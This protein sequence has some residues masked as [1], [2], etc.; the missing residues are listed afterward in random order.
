MMMQMCGTG[1]MIAGI[2]AT[3]LGVGLIASLIVLVWVVIARLRRDTQ[4][5]VSR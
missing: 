2:L 5:T 1:M 3:I 4:P